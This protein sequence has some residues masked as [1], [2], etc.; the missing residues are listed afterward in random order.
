MPL[1]LNGTTGV[2]L[3]NSSRILFNDGTSIELDHAGASLLKDLVTTPGDNTTEKISNLVYISS[4]VGYGVS[5]DEA[6]DVYT[7]LGSPMFQSQPLAEK[8]SDTVMPVH[9]KIRRCLV[10]DNGT[11][12]Y[13][14]SHYN[15]NYKEDGVTASV[16]TG[17]DGQVMVE[18][19]KFWYRYSYTGTVHSWEISHVVLDGFTVHPAFMQGATEKSYIYVGAYEGILYDV[20]GSTYVD[21]ASGFGIDW[22]ADKLSSVSGKRPVTQGTRANFRSACSRRGTGWS[23]VTYD[24]LSAIQLL[25][26]IE[27]ASF[28]SQV[29]IGAGITNVTDWASI[30]S[31]PFALSGNSNPIGN[32][33]G[34]TAGGTTYASE[35]TKYMS[36]RGIENFYGHIWKFV[37]GMN[38]NDNRVYVNNTPTQFA[39]DT[40]TNYFDIGVNCSNAN[41]YQNTLIQIERG[42]LPL[43]STASASTKTTDYYW[44]S[45]GWR[46][47]LSGSA[48]HD[49]VA[50]GAFSLSLDTA[51][52]ALDAIIGSRLCFSK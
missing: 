39:D 10:A 25:Y 13:Y 27:Y 47:A 32:K 4:V 3:P 17:A 43:T 35:A 29:T 12:N 22:N 31:Y 20:S 40:T 6:T 30:S 23:Q 45:T 14:L 26:L 34:N 16:L 2:D 8:A 18:I 9:T 19:P 1:V 11:V 44:Q 38:T 33:T 7:R 21:Y 46:V 50:A 49:G 41:G 28:N 5:W 42:F 51:S 24:F 52:S 37:D 15:S 48:S 36:Y